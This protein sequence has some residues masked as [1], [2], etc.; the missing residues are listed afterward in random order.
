MSSASNFLSNFN[1]QNLV[2]FLSI[3]IIICDLFVSIM[4]YSIYF[5]LGFVNSKTQNN[6]LIIRFSF[7]NMGVKLNILIGIT[8]IFL[9]FFLCYPCSYYQILFSLAEKHFKIPPA[10]STVKRSLPIPYK[11]CPVHTIE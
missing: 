3:C 8:C 9:I 2:A 7:R 4:L 6:Y 1:Q 10:F 5:R 11:L